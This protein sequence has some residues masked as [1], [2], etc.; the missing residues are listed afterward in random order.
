VRAAA[1]EPF[2]AKEMRMQRHLVRTAAAL[3]LAMVAAAHAAAQRQPVSVIVGLGAGQG[4]NLGDFNGTPGRLLGSTTPMLGIQAAT[5]LRGVD[6]R[7]TAQ[8]ATPMLALRSASGDVLQDRAAVTTVTADLVMNLPR[9]G[10]I[11]PYLLAGAGVRRYDFDQA[12]YQAR[13]A[14][15]VPRDAVVPTLHAGVGAAWK[16]GRA[17]LFTEASLVSAHYRA[18]AV[19]P[20]SRTVANLGYTL[21]V[22]IPLGGSR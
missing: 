11:R 16:L 6:L 4:A 17:E 18:P 13:G 8:H 5:P 10:A 7:I 3:A 21:G 19:A 14:T 20:G 22:R 2:N 12:W 15:V 1:A 9:I